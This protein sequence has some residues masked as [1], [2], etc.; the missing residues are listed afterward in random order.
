MQMSDVRCASILSM[1]KPEW[2][3]SAFHW[4]TMCVTLPGGSHY[5]SSAFGTL[6]P[7]ADTLMR[8]FVRCAAPCASEVAVNALWS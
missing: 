6:S 4:S 1:T 5:D 2:T 7:V 8:Y 3:M